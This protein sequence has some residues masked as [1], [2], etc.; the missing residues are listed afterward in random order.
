MEEGYLFLLERLQELDRRLDLLERKILE[1]SLPNP[2]NLEDL[3]DPVKWIENIAKSSLV[4]NFAVYGTLLA[5]AWEFAE[6]T[7]GRIPAPLQIIT[8]SLI[9][10]GFVWTFAK[11]I[12]KLIEK[13]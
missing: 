3:V 6:S 5:S 10:G 9:I 1:P 4:R 7:L 2:R 8:L 11:I 13:R 12:E